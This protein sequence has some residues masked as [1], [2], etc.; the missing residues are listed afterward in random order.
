MEYN[1]LSFKKMVMF[2]IPQV[3]YVAEHSPSLADSS[4]SNNPADFPGVGGCCVAGRE[5]LFPPSDPSL[6]RYLLYWKCKI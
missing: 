5:V 1:C 2:P 4:P 6:S 3:S